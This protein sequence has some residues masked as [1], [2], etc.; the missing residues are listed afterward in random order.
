MLLSAPRWCP[1]QAWAS[2]RNVARPALGSMKTCA[3]LSCSILSAKS[4]ASRRAL[5]KLLG[6]EVVQERGQQRAVVRRERGL[7]HFALQDRQLVPQ[8]KDLHV[9]VAV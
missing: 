3:F 6:R 1:S 9:L 8:R 4:S 5:P 7:A 2:A